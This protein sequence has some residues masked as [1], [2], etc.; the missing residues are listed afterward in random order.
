[1]QTAKVIQKLS[2][3][4]EIIQ[5]KKV[6]MEADDTFPQTSLSDDY[7]PLRIVSRV[8]KDNVGGRSVQKT[9]STLTVQVIL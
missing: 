9:S 2:G 6:V 4:S 8:M 3:L 5:L 1:M 7:A